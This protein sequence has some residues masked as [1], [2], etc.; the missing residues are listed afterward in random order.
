MDADCD[1]TQPL[2]KGVDGA[3]A[4]RH[5]ASVSSAGAEH[6]GLFNGLGIGA[7]IAHKGSGGSMVL[8]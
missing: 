3:C 8:P 6:G 5:T 4:Y 1:I 7:H 2:N